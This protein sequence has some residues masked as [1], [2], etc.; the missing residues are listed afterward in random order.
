MEHLNC[1]LFLLEMKITSSVCYILCYIPLL[2][3]GFVKGQFIV[4]VLLLKYRFEAIN[5]R[6]LTLTKSNNVYYLKIHPTVQLVQETPKQIQN[7]I[8]TTKRI[9]GRLCYI[10]RLINNAFSLQILCIIGYNFISFTAHAYFCIELYI[11]L[12]I[13]KQTVDFA[14]GTTTMWAVVKLGVLF[15]IT[16]TCNQTKNE[17]STV[18]FHHWLL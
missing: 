6:L 4:L 3:G 10:G 14:L 1:S 15:H 17:V 5:S 11:R 9:H 7:I 16:Y 8:F 2:I 18:I 13:E 12:Y